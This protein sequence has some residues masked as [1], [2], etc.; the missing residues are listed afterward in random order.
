MYAS[1]IQSTLLGRTRILG[2]WEGLYLHGES[3]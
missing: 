1:K 3:I 2:I